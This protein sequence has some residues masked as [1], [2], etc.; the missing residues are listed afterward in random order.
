MS[1]NIGSKTQSAEYNRTSP[2]SAAGIARPPISAGGA[3]NSPVL[4]KIHNSTRK[5]RGFP[6]PLIHQ[7]AT[8]AWRVSTHWSEDDPQKMSNVHHVRWVGWWGIGLKPQTARVL[9][10]TWEVSSSDCDSSNSHS[11]WRVL[12]DHTHRLNGHHDIWSC[13][14]STDRVRRLVDEIWWLIRPIKL[15]SNKCCFCSKNYSSLWIVFQGMERI[16]Y[17]VYKT[18]T[19]NTHF[20]GVCGVGLFSN[21]SLQVLNVNTRSC[22]IFLPVCLHTK[23]PL[24]QTP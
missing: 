1:F 9:A 22:Q 14:T 17:S 19:N 13:K 18:L 16:L 4:S 3:S 11:G 6:R 15:S 8:L 21:N 10:L 23:M 20:E 2:A 7:L 5:I 24:H 12:F